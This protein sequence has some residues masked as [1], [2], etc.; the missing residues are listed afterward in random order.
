M[1]KTTITAVAAGCTVVI[2][3][4]AIWIASAAKPSE[5]AV[6]SSS[7]PS[8][9]INSTANEES[10]Q[11]ILANSSVS[12]PSSVPEDTGYVLRAYEGH[13]GIFRTGEDTP[14]E[15]MDVKLESLPEADQ[16]LLEEGI[17]AKDKETLR[18]IMEDYES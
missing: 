3:I 13:I 6:S 15:E 10:S 8:M 14:I 9:T 12:E 18:S 17:P 4:A 2:L 5:T 1:K 11:E 7:T 16:K